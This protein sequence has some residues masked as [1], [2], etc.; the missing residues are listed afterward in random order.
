MLC[1]R[2][3]TGF[4]RLSAIA[5]VLCARNRAPVFQA[6]R[7]CAPV[8]GSVEPPR[9]VIPAGGWASNVAGHLAARHPSLLVASIFPPFGPRT[10]FG[11]LAFE[12]PLV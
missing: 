10:R 12:A 9:R 8:L 6:L 5:S 1:A 7:P 2:H 4:V 11:L 3:W